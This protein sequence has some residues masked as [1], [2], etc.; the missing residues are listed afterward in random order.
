MRTIQLVRASNV[1]LY[2]QLIEQIK[3]Q[4]SS[5]QLP[6]GTRLPTIR[7]LAQQ[8]GITR[9][10][11]QNAYNELQDNGWIE[12]TIGRGT[13]V[14]NQVQPHTAMRFSSQQ[15]TPDAVISDILQINEVVGTRSLASA[16]P[17]PT[18]FPADEFW[19][20]LLG[21]RSQMIN[22][23][24]YT[25]SQGDPVLRV[26]LAKQLQTRAIAAQPD[27]ILVTSGVTQALSLLMQTL[28][29]PGDS[30]AVEQPTYLGLLHTIKAQG[31]H[32]VGVPFDGEGPQLDEL[33]RVIHQHRPRF[34]YTIPSFQN[35]TGSCMSL[36][37]RQALLALAQH[38]GILLVEDDI[39]A[40]LAYDQPPPPPLKA[41][42]SS[43]VVVHVSSFAKIFMPGLRI[44]Y[45]VAPAPI[46]QNLLSMRRATDLCGSPFL[47]RAMASFLDKRGLQK[48]LR[49]VL[50][51]YR[52]RR[53]ALL[54]ALQHH[55]PPTVTWTKPAGGFC[56]WVTLPRHHGLKNLQ[57]QAL[58][59]GWA[60]APGDVFLPQ[61]GVDYHLRLCFG[62][63]T[64]ETIRHGVAT[65]A[66]LIRTGLAQ[67]DL[68]SVE[69]IDWTPLV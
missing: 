5:Q 17:D 21:L 36:A 63:Q 6:A 45:V 37:R 53:D 23:V 31:L 58:Q 47:Q 38:S 14:S 42:D 19:D 54:G 66:H 34:F 24:S 65:L 40:P 3:D 27:E 57:S 4:I 68:R 11:V 13:F 48:H 69:P 9:S 7:E 26:E 50:P 44:G 18:L 35:P 51:I 41:L 33:E 12:S 46:H 22:L 60:F 32:A 2:Q 55:M 61:T 15:L 43:S 28:C 59:A 52:E 67:N 39:Y 16:S 29:R 56:C 49:R 20:A 30:V 8:L 64:P 62:N 25:S 1:A 10:T